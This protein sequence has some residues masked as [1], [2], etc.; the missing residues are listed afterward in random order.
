MTLL[1]LCVAK[2]DATLDEAA[3]RLRRF[4]ARL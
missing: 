2:Q 1:R 4:A 3:Q